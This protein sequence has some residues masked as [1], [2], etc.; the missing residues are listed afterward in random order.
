MLN[1]EHSSLLVISPE[2]ESH[3]ESD[4]TI[5]ADSFI[6][7]DSFADHESQATLSISDISPQIVLQHYKSLLID[8]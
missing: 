2:M 7:Q 6:L 3:L 1:Q 8:C 5:P 4:V